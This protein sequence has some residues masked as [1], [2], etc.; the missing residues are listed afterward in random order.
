MKLSDRAAEFS[1]A[2]LCL[3]SL[4]E[5][6]KLTL[7][8]IQAGLLR[9]SFEKNTGKVVEAWHSVGTAIRNGQELGLHLETSTPTLSFGHQDLPDYNLGCRIW[10]MLHLWDAH[11]AVILGRPMVTKLDPRDIPLPA[12]WND[13]PI[14]QELPRPRDV[15]LCGFHT[16]YKYLQ[17]IHGL[18][19]KADSFLVVEELHESILANIANLPAWATPKRSRSNESAWLSTA[20]EIMFTNV[21]FVLF[22]LHRPFVSLSSSSRSKA[23]YFATQILESQARLFDRTEPLQH[24]SFELVFATFDATILI[25]AMHIRFPD[26]FADQYPAAKRNLEWALDRLKLLEPTNDLASSALN[27]VQQLYQNMLA[28]V[29]PSQSL[30]SAG[31]GAKAGISVGSESEMFPSSWDAILQ[32]FDNTISGHA[33]SEAT[34]DGIIG[35]S[36]GDQAQSPGERDHPL[37]GSLNYQI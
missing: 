23:Y 36:S 1:D 17:D 33:F 15:I 30:P 37:L 3:A 19:K 6:S 7:T 16:A 22:A 28:S 31:Q 8:T 29:Y 9:A 13:S 10:L 5:K 25:A 14:E 24:K 21:H 11:M 12:S 35:F 26:E 18:E 34:C 4:V 20:L 27:V 2:G 32:P